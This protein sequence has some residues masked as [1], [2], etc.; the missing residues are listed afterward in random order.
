MH[1]CQDS[2]AD[3]GIGRLLMDHHDFNDTNAAVAL[4]TALRSL[5]SQVPGPGLRTE[6]SVE[7]RGQTSQP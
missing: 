3:P 5:I 7:S 2:D 4:V 6:G 1:L